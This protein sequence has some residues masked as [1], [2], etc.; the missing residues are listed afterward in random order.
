MSFVGE[1]LGGWLVFLLMLGLGLPVGVGLG[2]LFVEDDAWLEV[3]VT[4]AVASAGG[5]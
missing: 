4:E 5:V 3:V 2:A 1:G